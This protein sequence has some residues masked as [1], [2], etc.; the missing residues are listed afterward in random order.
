MHYKGPKEIIEKYITLVPVRG[1]GWALPGG[2]VVKDETLARQIAQ[3]LSQ[4]Y[5]SLLPPEK[6]LP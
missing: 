6:R 2:G 1:G 3:D 5:E 4:Y